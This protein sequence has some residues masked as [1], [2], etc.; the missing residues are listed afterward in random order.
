V[1]GPDDIDSLFGSAPPAAPAQAPDVPFA[2]LVEP[3]ADG[4]DFLT[5][6]AVELL[7]S[8]SPKEVRYLAAYCEHGNESKAAKQTGFKTVPRNRRIEAALAHV[9]HSLVEK[10]KY[11]V[12]ETFADLNDAIEF[13]K[14]HKAAMALIRAIELKAKVAGH[15]AD[16]RVVGKIDHQ[17][18]HTIED[19]R[20]DAELRAH[21]ERLARELGLSK[22][23]AID[24]EFREI[25]PNE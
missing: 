18:T 4:R 9:Q 1:K 13:A 19:N 6:D 23:A 20:T 11:G 22:P 15:M 17:H 8:L 5:A 10:F 12:A 16:T 14:E 24:A 2:A 3:D 25:K 21:A 7:D